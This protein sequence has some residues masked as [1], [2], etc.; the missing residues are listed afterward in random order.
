MKDQHKTKAQLLSELADLRQRVADLEALEVEQRQTEATLI[1]QR[2]LMLIL[3][4]NIPDSIYFKDAASRFTHINRAQARILGVGEPEEAIGKTDHD[5]FEPDLAQRFYADEQE[6][7]RSGQPLIDKEE[8]LGPHRRFRWVSTTK[9]P[10]VRK[11]QVTGIVG[12][13]RDVTERKQAEEALQKARNELEQRVEERTV[14]LRAINASLQREILERKR[15]EEA[16]ASHTREMVAL[17]ETS[18]EVSSQP[19]LP[20]LLQAIVER[21]ARLLGTPR[22]SLYLMKPDGETLQV[23]VSYNLPSAYVGITLRLGEGLAGRVARAGTPL[24]VDDYRTWEGQAAVFAGAP[25]RRVLGV[26]LKSG[27]TVIGV[28]MVNGDTPGTFSE[29]DVRL[30]S[31]FADQAALAVEKTRLYEAVQ[32]ELAERKRAEE[33]LQQ[34]NR[35]LAALNAELQARNEE[36]DAFAHTVAHDLQNPLA[37]ITGLAEEVEEGYA[38]FPEEELQRYLQTMSRNGRKM[39]NIV[40]GLLILA[41]VRKAEVDSQPLDMASLVAEAQQRLVDLIRE[42]QAEIILPPTW[43]VAQGHAPWVEEVWLNYLSNAIKY[44]GQPPRVE[45]GADPLPNPSLLAGK[46]GLPV[47]GEGGGVVRFWVRDNGDGIAPET[48]GRLF[49]PFT[50]LN[51]VRA[52]GHG[53]GLSIVRRIVEKLG[54][55]I[56]VESQ[57]GQGSTFFFTLPRAAS[58]EPQ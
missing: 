28:I 41:G 4:D 43:P 5:F 38:T 32:H 18:L 13:S 46:G 21:A 8:S 35:E 11:G 9:V 56:G 47:A 36:L 10:I 3:M 57:V 58:P 55:Q 44:G 53:L 29:D 54:G 48:L 40:D 24:M 30:V 22:G 39:S 50:R 45:V 7:V 6:I 1:L 26:P 2:D 49:T 37:I 33:M 20:T 42:R 34:R 31:L 14:E 27:D 16:L 23:A 19:D 15:A 51:Q 17:Y 12:I 52:R 25:F